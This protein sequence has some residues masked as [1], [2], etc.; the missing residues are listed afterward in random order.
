[1]RAAL[2]EHY[3]PYDARLADWLGRRLSWMDAPA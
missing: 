2:A 1:V 3:A